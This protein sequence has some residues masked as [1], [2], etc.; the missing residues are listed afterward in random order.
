MFDYQTEQPKPNK[1]VNNIIKLFV[2]VNMYNNK[3][4]INTNNVNNTEHSRIILD[5]YI[6]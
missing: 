4:V 3:Y 5:R 1:D 6:F 2:S